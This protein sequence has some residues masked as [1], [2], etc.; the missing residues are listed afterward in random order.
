MCKA[1]AYVAQS[2]AEASATTAVL[3]R[4]AASWPAQSVR[5]TGTRC[6]YFGAGDIL[7]APTIVTTSVRLAFLSPLHGN[8]RE[9]R[10]TTSN[11]DRSYPRSHSVVLFGRTSRSRSHRWHLTSP[12][13]RRDS[14][15]SNGGIPYNALSLTDG[16][17]LSAMSRK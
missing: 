14:V 12:H 11:A 1:H 7:E 10:R 2:V 13:W 17:T 3:R 5:W 6:V 15:G 16:P 9:S 8:P 4:L